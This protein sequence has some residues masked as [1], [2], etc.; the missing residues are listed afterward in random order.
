M[1]ERE[2]RVR[3][4]Y[5][6]SQHECHHLMARSI[7]MGKRSKKNVPVAPAPVPAPV[8]TPVGK[9]KLT[10]RL[11]A[12]QLKAEIKGLLTDLRSTTDQNAKKK[13][14]RA[15]RTRGHFGGLGIVTR[16]PAA[17]D[18]NVAPTNEAPVE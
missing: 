18:N 15:L 6:S 4:A 14:R 12:D 2:S 10:E 16:T 1:I 9:G 8:T 13:I 5:Q 3:R 17:D 11:S 7:V